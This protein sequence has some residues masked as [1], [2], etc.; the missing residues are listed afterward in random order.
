VGVLG[1]LVV[2]GSMVAF[3]NMGLSKEEGLEYLRYVMV[4]YAVIAVLLGLLLLRAARRGGRK[5]KPVK[6]GRTL[7]KRPAASTMR[8]QAPGRPLDDDSD[9]SEMGAV[10]QSSESD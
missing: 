9:S 3:T 10:G 2:L 5:T 4:P 7:K 6:P 8:L 1:P